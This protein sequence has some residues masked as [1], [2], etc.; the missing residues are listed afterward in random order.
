MNWEAW[1]ALA[2][3]VL[4]LYALVR[5]LAG[6]DVILMAAVAA[7]MTLGLASD[8]FPSP[9]QAAAIF[10]NEGLL[11]VGVLFV[12]AA[13]LTETGALGLLTDRI[14]GRPSS[15]QSAQLRLMLPVAGISG[16]LNNTP[17]VAM[18]MP[19]VNDWCKR[20]GLSPSKLFI[21]LSYA[22]V[23]GGLCTL[24]GTSTN[25]VVQGLLIEAQRTDPTVQTF[26]MFTFTPIGLPLAIVGVAFIVLVSPRL[27][28]S[29]RQAPPRHENPREYTL[30]MTVKAES[31][32]DGL[33]IE[34]A[35]LR[36]LPGAYLAAIE[37]GGLR[38][39]PVPPDERLKGG[40]QLTFVG[41]VESM[42]DL[43]KM[44]GLETAASQTGQLPDPPHAR[45]LAEA[46]VSPTCPLIGASIRDGQFRTRYEAVVVAVHRNGERVDNRIGDIVLK[47]GDTLLLE[48]S[49]RFLRQQRNSRDFFLVSGVPDSRPL[50][51]DRAWLAL[52]IMIVM[53][54]VASAEQVTGV[55]IFHAALVAAGLMGLTGCL[56]AD[57]ARRSIDWA[58]LV[59]IGGA[60][61]LGRAI[62]SSGLAGVAADGIIGV[63]E[64][65]G[66]VGVLGGVYLMTLIFTE[67]LTNNAAAALAFPVAHATATSLGVNLMPFAVVIAIAASAGF[68]TPL[69]YQTHLMV[70]GPGGYRFSDYLR[71]GVPLDLLCMAITLALVWIVF[72]M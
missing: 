31:A 53:V 17:V 43:L 60:L 55:S 45:F 66:P 26:T 5:N 14:L 3:V 41:N 13:G 27:L 10:G 62:E 4:V 69:G 40:D 51:H 57:Q 29:R 20:S 16:F 25:L 18:F 7:I 30:E 70:Y 1:A 63:F 24:I 50:R 35:G 67:T 38:R 59:T 19:L 71:L 2:V 32:I 33:T 22:A 65:L 37:R 49:R 68:A 6:P 23:L 61:V 72:P 15:V 54:L 34:G 28:P 36:H 44:R 39:V 58:T 64:P 9:T 47:A 48:T 46:V 21:P 8:R 12:V 56:S 11:T 42:V 52:G